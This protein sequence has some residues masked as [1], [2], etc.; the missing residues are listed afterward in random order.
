MGQLKIKGAE[1]AEKTVRWFRC[2][3]AKCLHIW[4]PNVRTPVECPKCKRYGFIEEVNV[5]IKVTTLK[6]KSL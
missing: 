2:S 5:D 4:K 3:R 6:E 1:M